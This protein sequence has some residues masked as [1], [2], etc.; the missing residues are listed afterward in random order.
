MPIWVGETGENTNGWM[1]DA[2]A[3]LNSVGIGWCN[4]TYKR[5]D[6]GPNA[7]LLRITPPFIVDGPSGLAQ[8][9]ENIKFANCVPNPGVVSALAPN[10]NSFVNYPGG[11]NYNGTTGA[12]APVGSTVWLRGANGKY[13]SGENGAQPMTCNRSDYGASEAFLVAAASGTKVTLQSQG[14]YV[15]S[16]NGTGPMTC[17]RPS[18]SG[19]EVFDWLGNADGTVSLR[20]TNGQYVSIGNGT[21]PLACTNATITSTETFGFGPVPATVLAGRPAGTATTGFYPNPVA[22]RLTYQLPAGAQAHRLT[23]LDAAGRQVL[24]RTYGNTGPRNIVDL[25]ELKNGLYVIRLSGAAFDTSFKITK[26]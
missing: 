11:G 25:S 14:K 1:H 19:G 10:Q 15:S 9:L 22:G 13:V 24:S 4:W 5:F 16:E 6:T 23:V 20:G 7:A 12:A 21:G 18:I 3:S 2:A 17:G 26:Q 8:V